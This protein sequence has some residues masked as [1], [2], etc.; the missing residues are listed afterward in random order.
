MNDDV[1]LYG[2]KAKSNQFKTLRRK[3]ARQVDDSI[4]DE[5]DDVDEV[6]DDVEIEEVNVVN[7]DVNVNI[8]SAK[9]VAITKA[10]LQAI[11]KVVD[12]VD[13][14]DPVEE[15]VHETL[16]KA[17]LKLDKLQEIEKLKPVVVR[18]TSNRNSKKL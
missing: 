4:L 11:A 14:I 17:A 6:V 10:K 5:L 16:A 3:I 8:V 15:I 13:E 18:R 9:V 1:E 7:D 12:P 2:L